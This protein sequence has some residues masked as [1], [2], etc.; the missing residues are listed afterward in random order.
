MQGAVVGYTPPQIWRCS[1]SYKKK[2]NKGR[3]YTKIGNL[4]T[5]WEYQKDGVTVTDITNITD[6]ADIA[7]VLAI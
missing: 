2:T 7:K 3:R 1:Q 5:I 4:D 6:I